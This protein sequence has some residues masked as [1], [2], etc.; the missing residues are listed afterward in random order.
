MK[1]V[2]EEF[3]L[4]IPLILLLF[5]FVYKNR[6]FYENLFTKELLSKMILKRRGLSKRIRN[7]LLIFSLILAVLAIARPVIEKG[8]IKVKASKIDVVTAFD[9][10]RSMFANDIY[11]NRLEFAKRKF[12]TFLKEF[13]EGRIG[14]IGFSQRAFLIAPLTDDFESL[15]FLVKNMSLDYVSLR[16]T[17]ILAPLEVTNNLLKNSTNKALILFTDGGDEEDFSK[18]IEYAKKHHIKVFVYAIGTKKGGVIKTKRGVLKDKNGDIVVVRRN[19]KI[20]ELAL[21]SGG[22]FIKAT[23]SNNDIKELVSEIKKRFKAKDSQE[24]TIKDR[25][26]LFYYPLIGSILLLFA[27]LFSFPRREAV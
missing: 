5:Y 19:D 21:K 4:L 6:D 16:G 3:L 20:K 15:K 14:V 18:E 23:L 12:F 24:I 17:N 1:F 8:E 22:A 13:K 10:S 2:N 11:P 7:T 9:I 27:G 26:E 25:K